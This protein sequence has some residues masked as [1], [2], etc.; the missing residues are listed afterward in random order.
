VREWLTPD[1]LV[2]ELK[3]ESVKT[4]YNWNSD[5]SGP[6]YTK[7]GK[8]VRYAREDVD[9]WLAARAVRGGGDV[10]AA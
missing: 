3:L 8:H 5:G 6:P 10:N 1:D 9:T 2:R 7:V 4:V